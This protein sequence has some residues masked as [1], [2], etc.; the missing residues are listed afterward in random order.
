[1]SV[2]LINFSHTDKLCDYKN[3]SNKYWNKLELTYISEYYGVVN[4][5]SS[6]MARCPV[7]SYLGI[8]IC[9]AYLIKQNSL[10]TTADTICEFN[11]NL[12]N[13]LLQ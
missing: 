7:N 11:C 6:S 3:L 5:S 2:S 10:A 1:M 8:S 9:A 4:G 12:K 13:A